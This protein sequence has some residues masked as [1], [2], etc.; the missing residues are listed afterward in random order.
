MDEARLV[1]AA[2]GGRRDA[3]HTEA[4]GP[5]LSS[6]PVASAPENSDTDAAIHLLRVG[7]RILQV[8]ENETVLQA[9]LRQGVA[10]PCGCTQGL[11]G[12]CRIRLIGGEVAM[13]HYGGLAPEEEQNGYILACSTRLR[14]DAEISI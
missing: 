9:S 4:F 3:F 13:N 14:S 1:H 5:L 12:T 11:C 6:V 2:E 7:E 10:I 8:R